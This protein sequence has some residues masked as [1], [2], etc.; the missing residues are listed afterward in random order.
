MKTKE[1]GKKIYE[2]LEKDKKEKKEKETQIP[3]KPLK[4]N[5]QT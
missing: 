3:E 2:N 1:R 5:N 4:S